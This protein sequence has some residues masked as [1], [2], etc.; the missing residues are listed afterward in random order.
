MS[1][2]S[3]LRLVILPMVTVVPYN[4]NLAQLRLLIYT[5]SIK[6]NNRK[7]IEQIITLVPPLHSIQIILHNQRRFHC[8]LVRC[9]ELQIAQLRKE[10]Q[11]LLMSPDQNYH[12]T[13]LSR[14]KWNKVVVII[15]T[16]CRL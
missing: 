7:E 13:R 5:E 2:K 11:G 10:R 12:L 8:K 4:H 9:I 3:E 16:I 6:E 15:T 14:C 1:S